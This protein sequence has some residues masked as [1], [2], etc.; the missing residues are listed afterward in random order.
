MVRREWVLLTAILMDTTMGDP[1][2]RYHPVAWMGSAISAA[3]RHAPREGWVAQLSYGATLALGGT[4]I[5]VM[6]GRLLAGVLSRLP[7]QWG[8]LLEALVLKTT[9]AMRGLG[10][11]ATEIETAL[12][13]GDLPEGRR[14]LSWHLVSRDTSALSESQVVAAT[15]ESVAE[16]TSDGVVAPL[17]YYALGG[18]PGALAYRFINTGD[19]MLGYRDAAR[20]WLGKIPARWDDLANLAPARLTAALMAVAAALMGHDVGRAWRVWRRDA[21]VTASPNAGHPM[22]V[23]AGALG[24]ELEKVGHYRLGA[25]HRQ[26]SAADIAA[27]VRLM[28]VTAWL[29]VGLLAL[30]CPVRGR[31][32]ARDKEAT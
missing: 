3:Q 10:R 26:P 22:S 27:S 29:A 9:L 11:A 28:R 8:W 7:C 24:I 20:E 21:R 6:V 16:N 15:I 4:V 2:N 1:P 18:L 19:A 32:K 5:V 30:L 13:A 31:R 17:F 23:A 12:T 25:G 14:L